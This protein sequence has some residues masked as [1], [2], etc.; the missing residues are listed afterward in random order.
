MFPH[1]CVTH[2]RVADY[3]DDDDDNARF[4]DGYVVGDDNNG[5]GDV[6]DTDV[7]V[8]FLC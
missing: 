2:V 5:G 1:Y 3:D 4:D 8:D 6:F 7:G